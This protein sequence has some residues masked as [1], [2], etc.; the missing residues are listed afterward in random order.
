MEKN[1]FFKVY[2][3]NYD[4]M[5]PI[6]SISTEKDSFFSDFKAQSSNVGDPNMHQRLL[7]LCE[8]E[9]KVNDPGQEPVH[10][11]VRGR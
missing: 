2:F 5:S 10:G 8:C 4:A 1:P 6:Y 7:V 9:Q 11:H 3:W